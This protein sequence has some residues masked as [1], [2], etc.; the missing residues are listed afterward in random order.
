MDQIIKSLNFKNSF[1]M[2]KPK[3]RE[4]V[5]KL[6]KRNIAEEEQRKKKETKNQE[7]KRRLL[8]IFMKDSTL[9]SKAKVRD[10]AMKVGLSET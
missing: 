6:S 7:Q 2:P 10:I 8:D 4:R 3:M 9:W 1:P 5:I